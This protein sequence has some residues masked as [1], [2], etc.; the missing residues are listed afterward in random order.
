MLSAPDGDLQEEPAGREGLNFSTKV[1]EGR[2]TPMFQDEEVRRGHNVYNREARVVA[3]SVGLWSQLE[4][5]VVEDETVHVVEEL[6]KTIVEDKSVVLHVGY[7]DDRGKFG[8]PRQIEGVELH[9]ETKD[10]IRTDFCGHRR[11]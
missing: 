9:S 2:C 11:V 10:Q 3:C 1:L 7:V 5:F 8:V 4:V 6:E